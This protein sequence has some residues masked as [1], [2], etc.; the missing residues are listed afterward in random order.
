MIDWTAVIRRIAPAARAAP[1]DRHHS[2]SGLTI[3][4]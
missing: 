4:W 2:Q 3:S 1:T